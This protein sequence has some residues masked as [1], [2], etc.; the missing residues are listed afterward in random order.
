MPVHSTL[1]W[2]TTASMLCALSYLG[3][4]REVRCHIAQHGPKILNAAVILAWNLRTDKHMVRSWVIIVEFTRIDRRCSS[5][6]Y[7]LFKIWDTAR[8]S[9]RLVS[10]GVSL[11][12]KTAGTQSRKVD[13]KVGCRFRARR[14]AM[15]NSL[16]SYHSLDW[17]TATVS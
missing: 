4:E 11:G 5:V 12:E 17:L 8:T 3:L 10:E 6:L 1:T 14:W 15:I 13:T 2:M 16:N 9:W 7:K